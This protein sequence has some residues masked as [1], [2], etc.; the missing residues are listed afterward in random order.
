MG[1]K[2]ANSRKM[3]RPRE[4]DERATLNAAMRIFWE[5]GYEGTSLD[6]LTGAMRINRSSLYSTFGDKEA[7]FRKVIDHYGKGPMSFIHQALQL[8]TARAVIEGLFRRTVAFL[9]DPSH[10][11]GCLSLQGGLTCGSGVES[12]RQT[13]IEWRESGLVAIRERLQQAK[14]NGD[15]PGDINPNDLARYVLVVMNGLGV[16][17]ANGATPQEMKRAVE[18]ALRA[19]PV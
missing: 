17:A 9:A 18:V 16:Q 11:R 6:D 3:G 13:M 19:L 14:Q 5:K 1:A 12:V 8:G 15:L 7:L 4:F 10:P 2:R